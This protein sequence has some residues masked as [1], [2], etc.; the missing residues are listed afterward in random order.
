MGRKGEIG[1]PVATLEYECK[2]KKTRWSSQR[3][4]LG[5][6]SK[7]NRKGGS[8]M[9]GA[10][11]APDNVWG[12]RKKYLEPGEMSVTFVCQRYAI[13]SR[14]GEANSYVSRRRWFGG[15]WGGGGGGGEVTIS[16]RWAGC[17]SDFG[18]LALAKQISDRGGDSL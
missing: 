5:K 10:I 11:P 6:K 4:I 15:G 7:K 16:A 18:Q 14:E 13:I 17:W 12:P 9:G 1:T 3:L 8:E 2:G